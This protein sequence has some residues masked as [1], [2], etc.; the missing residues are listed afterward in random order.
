MNRTLADFR[1]TACR[2]YGSDLPQPEGL[3]SIIVA[4]TEEMYA[5]NQLQ[6]LDLAFEKM[7]E[8]NPDDAELQK[9]LAMV[10][11]RTN[12]YLEAHNLLNSIDLEKIGTFEETDR[13]LV[14]YLP[15]L[16]GAYKQELEI[17]EKEKQADDLPRVEIV[18][19]SGTIVVEL[20]ENEAPETVAKRFSTASS[21][22]SW[23][24]VAG[25]LRTL[26]RRCL[27]TPSTTN[28]TNQTSADILPVRSAWPI[29]GNRGLPMLVF[30]SILCPPR[31]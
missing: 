25:S 13:A 10:Y 12:R 15:R 27:I 2:V 20:F 22:I 17:R 14:L 5:S 24:R 29:P 7:L 23:L 26:P 31:T 28:S 6:D 11:L 1:A 16:L 18:M 3:D 30:L 4:V 21:Q 9:K 8:A 19:S